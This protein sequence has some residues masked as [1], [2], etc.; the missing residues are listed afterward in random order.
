M[1]PLMDVFPGLA[2][3]LARA[4]TVAS[5]RHRR[6]ERVAG[7]RASRPPS[8]DLR[9]TSGAGGS[10]PARLWVRCRVHAVASGGSVRSATCKA[11]C[12]SKR[13]RGAVVAAATPSSSA[14]SVRAYSTPEGDDEE[15]FALTPFQSEGK[16]VEKQQQSGY[17]LKGTAPAL[18]LPPIKTPSSL[19]V[20]SASPTTPALPPPLPPSVVQTTTAPAVAVPTATAVAHTAPPMLNFAMYA[21]ACVFGSALSAFLLAMIPTLRSIKVGTVIRGLSDG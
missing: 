14:A 9:S 1:A 19:A 8:S 6:S 4:T 2:Q 15:K 3:T 12:G 21:V 5:S 16:A 18:P 17:A 11:T 20:I 7:P 13:T 10:T